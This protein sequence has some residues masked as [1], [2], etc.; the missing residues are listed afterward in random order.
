[1]PPGR[2]SGKNKMPSYDKKVSDAEVKDVIA[3][4]CSLCK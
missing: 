4:M 3:Y 2:T 1:M